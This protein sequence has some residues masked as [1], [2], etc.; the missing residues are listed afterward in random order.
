MKK[1]TAVQCQMSNGATLEYNH[2][3]FNYTLGETV[4]RVND[5]TTLHPA[6]LNDE[7]HEAMGKLRGCHKCLLDPGNC[8]RECDDF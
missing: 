7:L 4:N 2:G 8:E 3:E 5:G 6:A 1:I